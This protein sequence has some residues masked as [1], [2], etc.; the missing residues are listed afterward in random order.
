MSACDELPELPISQYPVGSYFLQT[1]ADG[2]KV[3]WVRACEGTEE[4][5]LPLNKIEMI[6]RPDLSCKPEL[7]CGVLNLPTSFIWKR[8]AP[9]E[10]FTQLV[11]RNT[12]TPISVSQVN[13][14]T[15]QLGGHGEGLCIPCDALWNVES[16]VVIVHP[17]DLENPEEP[18][19][20][21]ALFGLFTG[22]GQGQTNPGFL[23]QYT[24]SWSVDGLY[25]AEI[26]VQREIP[27]RAGACYYNYLFWE[28]VSSEVPAMVTISSSTIK[29]T[30]RG[31]MPDEYDGPWAM[32]AT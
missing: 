8:T 18:W 29:A 3:L 23:R 22:N 6:N 16:T 13:A 11:P 25:Y 28:D 24:N 10:E 17:L 21:D 5:W 12:M 15:P 7:K 4:D 2:C 27:I 14:D 19:S 31:C 20:E 1:D 9:D 26:Y 32:G 30:L